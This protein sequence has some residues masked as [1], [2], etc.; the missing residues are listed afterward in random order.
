MSL[1]RGGGGG[2]ERERERESLKIVGYFIYSFPI[3]FMTL[4]L[5]GFPA[6]TLK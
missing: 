6:P 4:C 1:C 5:L 2:G 3:P